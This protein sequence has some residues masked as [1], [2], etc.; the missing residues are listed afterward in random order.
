MTLALRRDGTDGEAEVFWS[1]HPTGENDRDVTPDDL[2]PF[3]G[4][5]IFLTG[6]S[7]AEINITILA[8]NIPEINETALLTLDRYSMIR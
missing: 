7:D 5:V 6:Q 8:D 3:R 1:L 4:S 2:S